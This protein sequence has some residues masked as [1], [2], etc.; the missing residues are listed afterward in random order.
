MTGHQ[1]WPPT[2]PGHFRIW[3]VKDAMSKDCIDNRYYSTHKEAVDARNEYGYGYV[4]Y[5]ELKEDVV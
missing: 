4:S 5:H 2:K 1:P 3:Y